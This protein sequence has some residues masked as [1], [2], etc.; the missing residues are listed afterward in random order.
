M[1]VLLL[2]VSVESKDGIIDFFQQE[3]N[4]TEKI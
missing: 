2:D 4:K 3:F 1:G